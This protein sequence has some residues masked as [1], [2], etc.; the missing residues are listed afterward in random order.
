MN[1]SDALT[2][3][4]YWRPTGKA[5]GRRTVGSRSGVPALRRICS[6]RY[7][8]QL[9]LA[10]PTRFAPRSSSANSPSARRPDQIPQLSI[11]TLNSDHTNGTRPGSP[12]PRAMVADDDLALGRIVEGIS[13]SRVWP[14]SLIL[15]TEDD[16]QDGVD[17][18]DGHRT[19]ALAIGPH[20]RRDAVDNNNYNH[21][22]MIRTIQEIFRIPPRTRVP[23]GR[24]SD[25]QHLHRQGRSQRRTSTWCRSVALDEMN[26]PLKAL[27]GRQLWAA[28]QSLRDE[29]E[30]YRRCPGGCLEP[31]PLVRRKGLGYSLPDGCEGE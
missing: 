8:Y 27:A 18:V 16:A 24:A 17:H 19:I 25:D 20:I 12:T 15:V 31:D 23:Q 13:K 28:R 14:K 21:T 1:E 11:L 29:L 26:P 6:Q 7:P 3:T 9:D 2:W 30:G 4:D 10:F 22:S 5:S